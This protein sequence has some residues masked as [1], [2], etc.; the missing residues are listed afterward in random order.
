MTS[1]SVRHRRRWLVP[2]CAMVVVAGSALVVRRSQTT[3]DAT[4]T[5]PSPAVPVVTAPVASGDVP[6]E[7]EAIGRVAA[8]NA[9]TVRTLVSGQIEAIAFKDGQTVRRGDLLV[10]IDPRSMEATV[11]QDRATVDRD[12]AN[13]ANAEADLKRYIPLVRGGLV[14]VQQVQTQ[15]SLVAQLHGTVA[16]DL[17]ALDRDQVQLGYT[18]IRAPISGIL[19]LRL[20]DVGNLVNPSDAAG[21]VALTQ[22]QPITVLFALPQANLNEVQS[23]QAATDGTGLAVQAWTEDGSHELDEGRLSALSNQVDATSGTVTLKGVFPNP[24][25]LL[26][27]GASVSVRLVLDIQHDGLTVPTAAIDQG[28]QGRF[29]W[30][31]APDGTVHPTPVT[32]RQQLK[33]RALLSSGVKAGEQVVTDGQY[34]LTSGAHVTI[35]KSQAANVNSDGTPLQTNQPNRLGISP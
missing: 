6:I 1:S 8:F 11:D 23:R 25:Q 16:A 19:G 2:F 9:V 10:Q 24:K 26:W 34:G 17:A 35:Q 3:S 5:N 31:I 21:L 27:P 13:L 15:R 28:P 4:K 29:V 20:V 7:L 18:T 14:S 30:A 33:G 12:Q 22:I 32:L